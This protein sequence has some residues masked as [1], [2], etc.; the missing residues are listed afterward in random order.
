MAKRLGILIACHTAKV[1]ILHLSPQQQAGV[2]K[3]HLIT[4][5]KLIY[6][7]AVILRLLQT[8]QSI[9]KTAGDVVVFENRLFL[10]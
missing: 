7:L 10:L 3:T 8:Q 1:P 2:S 9:L 6:K 5:K 4:E